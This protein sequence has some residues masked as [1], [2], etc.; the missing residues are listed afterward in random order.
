MSLVASVFVDSIT[1][2]SSKY[3]FEA[4]GFTLPPL[5]SRTLEVTYAPTVAVTD[6]AGLSIHAGGPEHLSYNIQL[7]GRGFAPSQEPVI[8]AVADLPMDQGYQVRVTWYP[9]M[10]DTPSES[11]QISEYS[12]WRRVDDETPGQSRAVPDQDVLTCLSNGGGRTGVDGALWD[13]ITTIPAVNFDVYAHVSPTLRNN[14]PGEV[15]WSV[16][17]V[18]AHMRT[19]SFFFS[20]AD[21]GCSTD[22][23]APP[24]PTSF[25]AYGSNG[26]VVLRWDSVAAADLRE[27]SL[28]RSMTPNVTATPDR[29]VARVWGTRY[30][31]LGLQN[32][33]T[34]Y[35]GITASDLAGNEGDMK[36]AT[37][38]LPVGTDEGTATLPVE[39]V[40][41]QNFPNPFNPA[42]VIT[43]E[44]PKLSRVRLTI[45]NVLGQ[46]VATLAQGVRSA[47]YYREIWYPATGSGIYFCRLDAT[48]VEDPSFGFRSVRKMVFLK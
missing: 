8:R 28:Y 18:A 42:T 34:Y 21:S 47:G 45:L 40:L 24:P 43:F 17:R 9:S 13:F 41:R 26:V 33:S 48:S 10:Y 14:V 12:L 11:S 4:S 15:R 35:Y 30:T 39:F 46:E 29:L 3:A 23:I 44:L 22:N 38:M 6:S 36:M 20:A 32:G 37:A 7:V 27:Y 5:A 1:G 16:F 2:T 25:T 19:G 31:D